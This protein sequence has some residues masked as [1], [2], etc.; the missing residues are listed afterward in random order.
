[1]LHKPTHHVMESIKWYKRVHT[2]QKM[3]SVSAHI[4]QV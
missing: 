4:Q 2:K 1:M 3:H